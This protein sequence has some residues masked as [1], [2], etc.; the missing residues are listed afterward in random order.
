MKIK[1][2]GKVINLTESDLKRIAKKARRRL[3]V[4]ERQQA[5]SGQADED[6]TTSSIK[7]AMN[8]ITNRISSVK[9]PQ[10]AQEINPLDSALDTLPSVS[11]LKQGLTVNDVLKLR[12]RGTLQQQ[13]QLLGNLKTQGGK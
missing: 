5:E 10:I 8:R 1:K 13:D 7:D 6:E 2:N 3:S 9:T 4:T 12:Y 11:Q